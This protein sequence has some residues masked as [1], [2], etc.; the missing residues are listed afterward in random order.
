MV[1][2]MGGLIMWILKVFRMMVVGFVVE[3]KIKSQLL[4]FLV[5]IEYWLEVQ[6]VIGIKMEK[7][8]YS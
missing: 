7:C 8:Q 4:K 3:N 5:D 2:V 1:R 6:L